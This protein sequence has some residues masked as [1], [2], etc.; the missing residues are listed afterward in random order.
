[1]N[2]LAPVIDAIGRLGTLVAAVG[3]LVF[4]W[5][6]NQKADAAKKAAISTELK[7]DAAK[8]AAEHAKA[9]LVEINGSVFTI[10]EKIDGRLTELIHAK[11]ALLEVATARA[12]AEGVAI[13]EQSERDRQSVPPVKP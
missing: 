6:N 5:R 2:D 4:T 1:M 10:G 8:E 12:R 9:L 11:D 3:A 7:A 13:G